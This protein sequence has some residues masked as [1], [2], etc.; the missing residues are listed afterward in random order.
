MM[1]CISILLL[2]C[3]AN[4]VAVQ[5]FAPPTTL[6]TRSAAAI[7]V[8]SF[9]IIKSTTDSREKHDIDP[10]STTTNGVIHGNQQHHDHSFIL[11]DVES[12]MVEAPDE[13]GRDIIKRTVKQRLF[14][15]KNANKLDISKN[16]LV[17]EL[18]VMR[19]MVNSCPEI[20]T[21]MN[22]EC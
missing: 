8:S 16:P 1:N 2:L 19:E 15:D 20:W 5:A 22:G 21:Y 17:N 13:E 12:I 4:E 10:L 9:N 18:R 11:R 7:R 6:K 3:A 14:G